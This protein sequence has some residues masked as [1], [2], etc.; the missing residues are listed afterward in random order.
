MYILQVC[1][2]QYSHHWYVRMYYVQVPCTTL[3]HEN[4]QVLLT[5]LEALRV[6]AITEEIFDSLSSREHVHTLLQ[7]MNDTL[8]G[9]A[10]QVS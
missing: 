10:A 3:T 6:Y 1:T 9:I 7:V 8:P 4:I 5:K 2:V